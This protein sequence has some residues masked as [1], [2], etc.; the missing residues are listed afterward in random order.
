V[1]TVDKA[2]FWWSLPEVL[3]LSSEQ[4]QGGFLLEQSHGSGLALVLSLAYGTP[5]LGLS[6]AIL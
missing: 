4:R 5:T 2:Q 3:G 6:N 1:N